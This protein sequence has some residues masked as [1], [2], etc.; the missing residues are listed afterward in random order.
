LIVRLD[1]WPAQFIT[2]HLKKEL[3]QHYKYVI[4]ILYLRSE[5]MKRGG[6]FILA[7][8]LVSYALQP[9]QSVSVDMLRQREIIPP[10]TNGNTEQ[11]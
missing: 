7:T 4:V 11:R 5:N 2:Q 1:H 8:V 6:V 9:L 3:S 10:Q